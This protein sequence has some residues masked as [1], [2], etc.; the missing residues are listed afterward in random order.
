[1]GK[2]PRAGLTLKYQFPLTLCNDGEKIFLGNRTIKARITIEKPL[3]VLSSNNVVSST[4]AGTS[5]NLLGFAAQ[6][7]T[8][9]RILRLVLLHGK[10]TYRRSRT[11]PETPIMGT[12]CHWPNATWLQ[13]PFNIEILFHAIGDFLY[14]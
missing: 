4:R 14:R 13:L 1:M 9:Q 5:L 12:A 11:A 2:H 7:K 3:G 8:I 10:A 6:K